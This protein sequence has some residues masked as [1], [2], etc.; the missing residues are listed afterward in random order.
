MTDFRQFAV[1]CTA[2]TLLFLSGCGKAPEAT[3]ETDGK[4]DLSEAS[5]ASTSAPADKTDISET[6]ADLTSAPAGEMHPT[7]PLTVV[8]A[9]E[10]RKSPSVPPAAYPRIDS[11][12]PGAAALNEKIAARYAPMLQALK[13]GADGAPLHFGYIDERSDDITV[14]R[15]DEILEN[16]DAAQSFYYYDAAGDKE[17]T[18]DEYLAHFG[19]DPDKAQ[20]GALW[21]YE[22]ARAKSADSDSVAEAEEFPAYRLTQDGKI[23]ETTAWNTLYYKRFADPAGRVT[24]RG[25]VVAPAE[26]TVTL[27]FASG[28]AAAQTFRCTLNLKT[29][30]PEYPSYEASVKPQA[31]ETD[32]VELTFADGKIRSARTPSAYDNLTVAVS[33]YKM[34]VYAPRECPAPLLLLNG[35][36]LSPDGVEHF[37]ECT[38]Y[39]FSQSGYIP[40]DRLE[41]VVFYPDA[42]VTAESYR[43]EAYDHYTGGK[44]YCTQS[45]VLPRLTANAPGTAAINEKIAAESAP[46]LE[47]LRGGEDGRLYDVSFDVYLNTGKLA[48]RVR[49]SVGRQGASGGDSEVIYYY[50]TEE[51]RELTAEEYLAAF[52]VDLDKAKAG[53][54]WCGS[55]ETSDYP[56]AY[57]Y[58]ERVGGKTSSELPDGSGV[59]Y[60]RLDR[61]DAS[62]V[63]DGVA[64]T[65]DSLLLF[66]SGSAY[67]DFTF[68]CALHRETLLPLQPD[69]VCKVEDWDERGDELTMT[70]SGGVLE[71]AVCPAG[72]QIEKMCVSPTEICFESAL[73]FDADTLKINGRQPSGLCSVSVFPR[74]GGGYTYSFAFLP[75]SGLHLDSLQAVEIGQ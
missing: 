4:T 31:A 19:V 69:F 17:L 22:F 45:V 48:L 5:T 34:S 75:A 33:A 42:P 8:A 1:L 9:A 62:V 51:N 28:D 23:T 14:L 27:Y 64:V 35:E 71:S 24:M 43:R 13:S 47:A 32:A 49:Q 61:F 55:C 52:G 20:E 25:A 3:G 56:P 46:I 30:L 59:F 41:S 74:D 53:A 39:R 10:Y 65:A 2:L 16:G 38:V 60:R 7:A 73:H 37:G 18:L 21:S 67:Q 66:F 58:A 26:D 36:A 44:L 12:A 68:T 57:V 15:I 63:L 72:A 40:P 29:L 50:D 54:L 11:D 6:S 70:F